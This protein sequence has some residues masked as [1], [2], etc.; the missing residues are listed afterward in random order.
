MKFFENFDFQ[1]TLFINNMPNFV[2]S[3]HDFGKSDDDTI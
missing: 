3:V 1:S 2:G